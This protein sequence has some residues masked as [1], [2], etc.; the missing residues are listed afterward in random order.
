MHLVHIVYTC[1]LFVLLTPDI[2]IRLPPNGN[3]LIV[4]FVHGF[5]FAIIYYLTHSFINRV[6][7]D[8][9]GFTSYSDS[10]CN[11]ITS[12]ADGSGNAYGKSRH[13]NNTNISCTN[14]YNDISGHHFLPNSPIPN[15][16]YYLNNSYSLLN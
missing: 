6:S 2:L 12:V 16:V 14:I 15:S 3:K 4:A 5:I 7:Y 1:L 8:L 13:S 10:S 9:E 11:I